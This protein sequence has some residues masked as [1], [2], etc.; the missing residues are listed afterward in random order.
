[1][2]AKAAITVVAL[3]GFSFPSVG[4]YG[5]SRGSGAAAD[6][7]PADRSISTLLEATG[8]STA[9]ISDIGESAKQCSVPLGRRTGGWACP[10][11]GGRESRVREAT[12]AESQ[13]APLDQR[14]SSGG[15][16]SASASP[17]LSSYCIAGAGCWYYHDGTNAEML[18]SGV[19]WGYGKTVLG[20][21]KGDLKWAVS[22]GSAANTALQRGD[23]TFGRAV[24]DVKLGGAL[25]NAAKGKQGSTIHDC[26]VRS[27]GNVASVGRL[28]IPTNACLLSDKK[29][30]DHTMVSTITWTAA[31]YPGRW[32]TT[33]CSIVAHSGNPSGGI[34]RFRTPDN[35]CGGPFLS[36]WF[37]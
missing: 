27:L 4:G 8:Q 3:I 2:V 29:A 26:P 32:F 1:M 21:Q 16:A 13:Q 23:Y 12:P 28:I 36:R 15:S 31:G 10:T 22:G 37:G 6:E 35:L 5:T 24:Q 7:N 34:Y 30:Y 25:S 17:S 14:P 9:S 18:I 20:L 33:V 11:S 19:Q